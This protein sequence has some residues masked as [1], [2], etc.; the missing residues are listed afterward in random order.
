MVH[1]TP[2][3]TAV[4]HPIDT[5][6]HPTIP[7]GWRWAV[8]VGSAPVADLEFCVNAGWCPTEREAWIEGETVAVAAIKALRMFGIP[9][10]FRR[11]A[12]D[13][14]PIPA[15]DDRLSPPV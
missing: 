12:L 4:V 6:A 15:G 7:E 2:D 5:E 9:A 10:E 13:V 11:L 8:H 1:L 3:V 14:D